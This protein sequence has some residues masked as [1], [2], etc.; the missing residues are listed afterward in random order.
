MCVSSV[1]CTSVESCCRQIGSDLCH[2]QMAFIYRFPWHGTI[3]WAI[4]HENQWYKYITM[5]WEKRRTKEKYIKTLKWTINKGIYKHLGCVLA[6]SAMGIELSSLFCHR[7]NKLLYVSTI[8]ACWDIVM[9]FYVVKLNNNNQPRESKKANQ[10]HRLTA[11][12]FNAIVCV[13]IDLNSIFFLFWTRR[14]FFHRTH[15]SI[16][17]VIWFRYYCFVF[18]L[19]YMDIMHTYWCYTA[20]CVNHTN[21]QRNLIITFLRSQKQKKNKKGIFI[22]IL[23]HLITCKPWNLII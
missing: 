2:T 13:C 19:L 10:A 12:H 17:L 1:D 7:V 11:I 3:K 22:N 18:L 23:F 21:P 8:I 4:T 16:I 5:R 20:Q 15:N 6:G 14:V 9:W